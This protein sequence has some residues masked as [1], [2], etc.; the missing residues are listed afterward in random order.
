[1]FVNFLCCSCEQS[2]I[3]IILT[4]IAAVGSILNI[5]NWLNMFYFETRCFSS[6]TVK[7]DEA[8]FAENFSTIKQSLGAVSRTSA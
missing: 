5:F 8:E 4:V 1:M 3:I 2:L 6:N 7:H